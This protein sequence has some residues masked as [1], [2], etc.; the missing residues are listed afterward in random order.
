MMQ[1]NSPALD[2]AE[3]FDITHRKRA[4]EQLR[5]LLALGIPATRRHDNTVCVLRVDL[6]ARQQAANASDTRPQR[7]STRQ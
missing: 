7:K 3:I 5:E 6:H 2:Q 4:K 1:N